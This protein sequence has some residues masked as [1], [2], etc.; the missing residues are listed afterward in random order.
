MKNWN[1]IKSRQDGEEVQALA[2]SNVY[3]EERRRKEIS[4]IFSF[5]SY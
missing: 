4:N 1:N 3:I 2:N 5:L